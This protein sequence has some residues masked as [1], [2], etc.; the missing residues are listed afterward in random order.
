MG[1]WGAATGAVS[2]SPPGEVGG[3]VRRAAR[4]LD[5]PGG[6][7]PGWRDPGVGTERSAARVGPRVALASHRGWTLDE[8]R[9][10]ELVG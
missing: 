1:G 6:L 3:G 4:G 7:G 2:R 5:A 10:G 9:I 8:V